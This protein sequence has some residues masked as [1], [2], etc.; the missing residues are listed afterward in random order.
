VH[1]NFFFTLAA[2][3]LLTS[4]INIHPKYCGILGLFILT[5]MSFPPNIFITVMLDI[6]Y[7]KSIY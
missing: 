5:G 6:S 2:V 1:W 3:A 7:P 4:I